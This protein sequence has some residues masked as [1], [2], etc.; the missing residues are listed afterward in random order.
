MVLWNKDGEKL[1]ASWAEKAVGL[2]WMHEKSDKY[3]YKL[4]L[5]LAIPSILLSTI[6]GTASFSLGNKWCNYEYSSIIIGSA[7]LLTTILI[8]LQ[9]IKEIARKKRNRSIRKSPKN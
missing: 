8:G 2:R 6:S 4:N 5:I 3:F 1:L 9:N 7:N